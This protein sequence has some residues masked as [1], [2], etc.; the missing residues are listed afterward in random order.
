MKLVE[1]RTKRGN[2]PGLFASNEN[3]QQSYD[4]DV[5]TQGN[6]ATS[7]LIDQQ[8][9]R[10]KLFGKDDRLRFARIQRRGPQ[11]ING[12]SIRYIASRQKSW[13]LRVVD[14]EFSRH[15][16]RHNHLAKEFP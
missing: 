3:A 5:T 13:Q 15:G 12:I 16:Q 8:G 10:V 1:K 4:F 2:Q 6:F 11:P 14:E 7:L 9:V